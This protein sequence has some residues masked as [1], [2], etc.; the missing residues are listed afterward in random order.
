MGKRSTSRRG[1]SFP[2]GGGGGAIGDAIGGAVGG[3][4][5]LGCGAD[6][7]GVEKVLRETNEG[8][9]SNVRQ[10][11]EGEQLDFGKG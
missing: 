1:G 3:K 10:V 11:G 5:H 9:G 7:E 6:F 4:R 8:K 2:A